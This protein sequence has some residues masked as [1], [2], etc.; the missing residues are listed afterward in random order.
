MALPT[1]RGGEDNMYTRCLHHYFCDTSDDKLVDT[2][3][4]SS[5]VDGF[6]VVCNTRAKQVFFIVSFIFWLW[7]DRAAPVCTPLKLENRL[8]NVSEAFGREFIDLAC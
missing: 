5:D 3:G 1:G 6:P 7:T 4:Y 2:V 8:S